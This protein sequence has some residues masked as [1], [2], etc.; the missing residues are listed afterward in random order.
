MGHKGLLEHVF[1]VLLYPGLIWR[2]FKKEVSCD[3]KA[4]EICM[5]RSLANDFLVLADSDFGP[6][7]HIGF[8]HRLNSFYPFV[9]RS[10]NKHSESLRL[11]RF[12]LPTRGFEVDHR[13]GVG[14]GSRK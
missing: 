11:I 2:S 10:Y 6:F 5:R 14:D 8:G 4:S 7:T 13:S 3:S 9:C 12:K 1:S